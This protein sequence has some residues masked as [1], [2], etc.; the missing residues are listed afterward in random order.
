M[1][2][3][4]D[5]INAA[6]SIMESNMEPSTQHQI[7][8]ALADIYDAMEPFI[9]AKAKADALREAAEYIGQCI[10]IG[11]AADSSP[12]DT[13]AWLRARAATIEGKSE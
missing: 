1:T 7:E 3:N 12:Q 8:G 5:A 10:D 2:T 13:V 4:Q 11:A 9:A 6:Y